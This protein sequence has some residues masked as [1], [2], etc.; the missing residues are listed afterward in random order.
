MLIMIKL[1]AAHLIGDFLLQWSAMLRSKRKRHFLSPYLYLHGLIHAALCLLLLWDLRYIWGVALIFI[2]HIIVDA[3]KN[4]FQNKANE[5]KLF[6][7]DQL[8]HLLVI[9]AVAYSYHPFSLPIDFADPAVQWH[10]LFVLALTFPTAI[11]LEVFFSRWQMP[12]TGLSLERAGFYIGIFERLLVYF[13]AVMQYWEL[14]GFMLTAKS[15]FRFGDLSNVNDRRYTEYVFL[16]TLLSF[17]AA[18][19]CGF[20]YGLLVAD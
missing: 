14:V 7:F 13:A 15:I 20:S 17:S 4:Y 1:L 5:R 18:I 6:V 19:F 11:T 10:L 16:G 2:S 3:L 9:F 12:D 8:L